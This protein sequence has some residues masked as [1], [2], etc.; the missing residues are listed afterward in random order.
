MGICAPETNG[1]LAFSAGGHDG[2][3]ELRGEK[4]PPITSRLLP[5]S[6]FSNG[7]LDKANSLRRIPAFK[8]HRSPWPNAK[9]DIYEGAGRAPRGVL[10]HAVPSDC[11]STFQHTHRPT[12]LLLQSPK[13]KH[14]I[15]LKPHPAHYIVHYFNRK[16][17]IPA[18][19][20]RSVSKPS[21]LVTQVT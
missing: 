11:S 8:R 17:S 7:Q 3:I 1:R 20:Y 15:T 5:T 18:Q 21:T 10:T 16:Y 14:N 19:S 9:M 6:F 13:I 4:I 12:S 2:W